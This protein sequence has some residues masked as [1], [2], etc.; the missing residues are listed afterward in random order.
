MPAPLIRGRHRS[1]SR[2]TICARDTFLYG[3]PAAPQR[4]LRSAARRRGLRDRHE[5]RSAM[6]TSRARPGSHAGT[7]GRES[8]ASRSE[9]S[10]TGP[11]DPNL[12][13]DHPWQNERP[14]PSQSTLGPFLKPYRG[15][16]I[17][18]RDLLLP[19]LAPVAGQSSAALS[20]VA[21]W[22]RLRQ[23]DADVLHR[24]R[25]R[26]RRRVVADRVPEA[27]RA[28]P[29]RV[30]VVNNVVV[31][32]TVGDARW[33]VVELEVEADLPAD[34]VVGAGRVAT[35]ADPT[36]DVAARVVQ[37]E[38]APE[39]VRSAD[40]LT[41]HVILG[42]PI[43]RGLPAV[44]RVLVDRIGLLQP[45]QTP[46]WLG[47]CVEIGGR[48]SERRQAER[49]GRVCLLGRDHAAA[50]PLVAFLGPGVS[51]RH[52]H[53]GPIDNRRPHVQGKATIAGRRV[54]HCGRERRLELV[55]RDDGGRGEAGRRRN[56]V[57]A[58]GGGGDHKA[59][60]AGCVTRVCAWTR[61]HGTV[62]QTVTAVD[63]SW[64]L[65]TGVSE[66]ARTR[67]FAPRAFA[68]CAPS[69]IERWFVARR[70]GPVLHLSSVTQPSP[71]RP[72]WSGEN[73][74]EPHGGN[75]RGAFG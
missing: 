7:A 55:E 9:C 33:H 69:Q 5:P 19:K 36:D 1:Q 18:T 75:G 10:D 44:G 73:M 59:G 67:G 35:H 12:H 56:V 13:L 58:A 4:G 14:Q 31:L 57:A 16:G 40:A 64:R 8:P 21:D 52:D 66:E 65:E 49:V 3:S 45:E 37:R 39:H 34:I 74:N 61:R 68:E 29:A 70:Y 20:S 48:E 53:T 71:A 38:S 27:A 50:G 15:A 51:H 41:H 42:R 60:D 17:R 62:L 28:L 47:G 72:C 63:P 54:A 23:V 46:A 11:N 32:A 30:D 6:A 2:Y 24:S 26:R 22:K 25:A 43:A